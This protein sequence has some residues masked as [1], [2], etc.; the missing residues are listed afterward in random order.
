MGEDTMGR[1]ALV[2]STIL[3]LG[4]GYLAAAAMSADR[5]ATFER[6]TTAAAKTEHVA[7]TTDTGRVWYGGTLPPI[8]VTGRGTSLLETASAPVGCRGN[9]AI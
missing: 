2:A 9:R 7:R 5:A 3:T 6:V 1:F 8:T 4:Y